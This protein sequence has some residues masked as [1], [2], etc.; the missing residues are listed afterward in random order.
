MS[1]STM[2]DGPPKLQRQRQSRLKLLGGPAQD[3]L[4]LFA[5]HL[6]AEAL[7]GGEVVG[8]GSLS[9]GGSPRVVG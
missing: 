3:L 6:G 4:R 7:D 2:P 9:H 1:S 8:L 5:L